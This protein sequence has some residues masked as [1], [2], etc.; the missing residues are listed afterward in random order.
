MKTIF[1]ILCVWRGTYGCVE[2]RGKREVVFLRNCIP[3]CFE[4]ASLT[5]LELTDS[6]RLTVQ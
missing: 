3:R 6:I 5:G 4:T 2:D 1:H